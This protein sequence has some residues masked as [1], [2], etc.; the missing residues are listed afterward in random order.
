MKINKHKKNNGLKLK[1]FFKKNKFYVVGLILI[2]LAFFLVN[3]KI[4]NDK[5]AATKQAIEE[6]EYAAEL[7]RKE[8][9]KEEAE[10]QRK[11]DEC[12]LEANVRRVKYLK[13]WKE[14]KDEA[15]KEFENSIE[16]KT[17]MDLMEN[18][19]SFSI[20]NQAS[21][22]VIDYIGSINDSY[23]KRF[24]EVDEEYQDELDRCAIRFSN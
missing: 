21:K 11:Y 2:T 14:E 17:A 4:E 23:S 13:I 6:I 12:V 16:Y 3:K 22:I 1:K 7:E 20:R 18:G 15:N 19:E 10:I 24:D 9:Q 5:R 8:K